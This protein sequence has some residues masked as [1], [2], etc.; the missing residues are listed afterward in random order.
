LSFVGLLRSYCGTESARR[1]KDIERK[2]IFTDYQK[3]K[4]P[5]DF[6]LGLHLNVAGVERFE[7]PT[8]GFG[9]R[10]SAVGT[11]PLQ[12]RRIIPKLILK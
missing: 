6:S 3:R 7:L 1:I 2:R 10:R 4:S 5:N 8:F 11:T 12:T 9:I